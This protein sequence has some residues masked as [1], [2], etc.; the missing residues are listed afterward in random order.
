[1]PLTGL[2]DSRVLV[3][4]LRMLEKEDFGWDSGLLRVELKA[5][6]SSGTVLPN[7]RHAYGQLQIEKED[8]RCKKENSRP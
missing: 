4:S 6:V 2:N 3:V 8:L 1:M 7:L 5:L